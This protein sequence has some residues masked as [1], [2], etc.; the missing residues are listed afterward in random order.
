MRYDELEEVT[1]DNLPEWE[2]VEEAVDPRRLS[3]LGFWNT[4]VLRPRVFFEHYFQ[5][6]QTPYLF[7]V[8]LTV[9]VA[10]AMDRLEHQ[11]VNAQLHE[12]LAQVPQANSWT[13]YWLT[14]ILSGLFGGAIFYYLGGWW[15]DVRVG[16]AGGRRD[17]ET[18]RFLSLYSAFIPGLL[19]VMSMVGNT[20]GDKRPFPHELDGIGLVL[21]FGTLIAATFYAVYVSYRGVRTVLDVSCWGARV[22]FLILPG[23]TY[24][25]VFGG[26]IT[27][28][29]FWG[30]MGGRG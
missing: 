16:W 20:V 29:L 2:V 12:R 1:D 7:W 3:F 10:R 6:G 11:F 22:W 25:F 17:R 15:Y 24:A 21:V 18:S 30:G 13:A 8:V 27:L 19:Q 9:G 23:L 28:G 5:K 4:L 14:A 26:A